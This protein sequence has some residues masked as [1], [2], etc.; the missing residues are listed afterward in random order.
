MF[1]YSA[2]SSALDRSKRSTL[3]RWQTCSLRHQFSFSG[4]HSSHAAIVQRLFT[5]VFPP[6]SIVRYSFIQLS[7]LWHQWRERKCPIFET[8]AKGGLKPGVTV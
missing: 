1:L 7:E 8:V 6:L 5:Y 2:V 4:K 3:Y